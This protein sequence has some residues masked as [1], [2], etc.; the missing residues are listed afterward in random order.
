MNGHT[1]ICVLST[2]QAL[3]AEVVLADATWHGALSHTPTPARQAAAPRCLRSL[4]QRQPRSACPTAGPTSGCLLPS[5]ATKHRRC[6][7][8]GVLR[9]RHS[10]GIRSCC[11]CSCSSCCCCAQERG[12]VNQPHVVRQLNAGQGGQ[13]LQ[14]CRNVPAGGAG[15]A[16]DQRASRDAQAGANRPTFRLLAAGMALVPYMPAYAG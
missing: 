7:W 4:L 14:Q 3:P 11:S 10:R 1:T 9:R 15:R 6:G 13:P 5:A 12:R 2:V 16:V 8:L